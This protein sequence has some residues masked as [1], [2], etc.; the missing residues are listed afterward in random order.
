[1]RFVNCL[2]LLIAVSLFSR[3]ETPGHFLSQFSPRKRQALP[4]GAG[5]VRADKEG[6]LSGNLPVQNHFAAQP[7]PRGH[8]CGDNDTILAR[9]QNIRWLKGELDAVVIDN[10]AAEDDV[11]L[12]PRV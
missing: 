1:M 3:A 11:P 9:G 7:F 10:G 4:V 12:P 6:G 8:L 2:M 5:Q